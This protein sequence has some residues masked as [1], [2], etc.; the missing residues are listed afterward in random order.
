MIEE[1]LPASVVAVEARV[2]DDAAAAAADEALLHPEEAALVA[3]AVAKRRRE[4]AAV[5][6]CARQAMEKLGVPPQP[7]LSGERGAPRW[8]EGLTGSMTHCDGYCA[9]ALVRT[10]DLASLGIDAEPHGPLP[11]GV[12]PVVTLPAERDRLLRL[13]AARPD[14]H[15]D[16]L[17]FSAK[18]SVYKA[19]FPL[20]GLWLDFSEAD[21]DLWAEPGSAEPGH[22]GLRAELLVPGPTVD[23]RRVQTFE[24][25][26]TVRQGLVATAVPVP[27]G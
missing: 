7:V 14:I 1:L 3:Q 16:R 19:W 24:G 4:F 8:P 11:E 27:H 21:I 22:G 26:W 13:A 5:R 6:S 10:G 20:T 23:G 18:E 2:D 12:L 25:R 17:L 15:W 9:A